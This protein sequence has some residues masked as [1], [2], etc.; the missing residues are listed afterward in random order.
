M[1]VSGFEDIGLLTP[2]R[3]PIVSTDAKLTH[4]WVSF[5]P[6]LIDS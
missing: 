2:L 3:R 4:R 1:Q 5:Q 6:V